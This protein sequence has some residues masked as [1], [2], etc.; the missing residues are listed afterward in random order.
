LLGLDV[1]SRRIGVAVSDELGM[2]A[3]PLEAV[4]RSPQ[5]L[6]RLYELMAVY[7]PEALIVGLPTGLSGREGV[8]A[9]EVRT[10]VE[11]IAVRVQRPIIFW[12]ERLTTAIAERALIDSG[13]RRTR[14]KRLV[15]AVAAAVMLQSYLDWQRSGTGG[16]G[17]R[18][19]PRTTGD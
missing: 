6:E 12:D 17:R 13:A 8:Q 18:P 10:F 16:T 11:E 4:E 15:D 19:G 9:A 2:I 3:S 5:G 1:G 7:D 14:R